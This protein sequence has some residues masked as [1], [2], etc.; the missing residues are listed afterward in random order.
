[1]E[2]ERGAYQLTSLA[3][4]HCQ[5]LWGLKRSERW[6]ERGH[7]G[8]RRGSERELERELER[9][10]ERGLNACCWGHA[11]TVDTLVNIKF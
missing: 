4:C 1:M 7:D 8:Q 11:L 3:V 6:L 9:G 2:E 5:L 10:S